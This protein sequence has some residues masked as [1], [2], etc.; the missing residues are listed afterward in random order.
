[1]PACDRF[2]LVT[3]H[4]IDYQ[5]VDIGLRMLSPRELYRAQGRPESYVIDGK[6][7]SSP[8][9]KTAQVRMCGNS[10]PTSRARTSTSQ[11]LR[12]ASHAQ[13]SIGVSMDK[14]IISEAVEALDVLTSKTP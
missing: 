2:G 4:G 3:V 12:T 5:I 10:V 7:D 14:S 6:P 9:T 13:T 1:M 8:L 11:L